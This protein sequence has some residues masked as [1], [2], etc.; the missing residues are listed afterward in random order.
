MSAGP[1][2]HPTAKPMANVCRVCGPGAGPSNRVAEDGRNHPSDS[3]RT[4]VQAQT[5]RNEHRSRN[6]LGAVCR[7]IQM[8]SRDSAV[9]SDS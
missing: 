7:V 8:A 4:I 2:C 3:L 5:H 1:S 6:E 9:C